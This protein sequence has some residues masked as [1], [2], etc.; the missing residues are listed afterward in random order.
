MTH[1]LTPTEFPEANGVLAAPPSM[2]DCSDLHV[3]RDGH[4]CISCW[5][6]SW[7]ARVALLLGGKVWLRVMSGMTQPPVALEVSRGGP[8]VRNNKAVP[9]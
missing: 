3:F 1:E 4:E 6:L 8:F 5:T 2:D 9:A 7:R